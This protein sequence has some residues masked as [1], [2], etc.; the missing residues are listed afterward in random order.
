MREDEWMTAS[1]PTPMLQALRGMAADRKFWMFTIACCRRV[2][3]HITEE[4]SRRA[5]ETAEKV[6]DHHLPTDCLDAV[7]EQ[8]WLADQGRNP[9][10]MAAVVCASM[11]AVD[12]GMAAW[13]VARATAASRCQSETLRM[14]GWSDAYSAR[15]IGCARFGG[16]TTQE[17]NWRHFAGLKWGYDPEPEQV[18]ESRAQVELVR[19]IFGNPFRPVTPDPRWLSETVV[20]L[21]CSIYSERAFDRMHILADALEEAGCDQADIL[22]HCRGDGPHVRGCWAVDVILGKQ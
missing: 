10:S 1:D 14:C 13:G 21:A 3:P 7:L 15:D 4:R 17:E 11:H 19:D 8:A 2:W 22:T 9:T 20:N 12:P 5:V 16:D 18:T 6:L